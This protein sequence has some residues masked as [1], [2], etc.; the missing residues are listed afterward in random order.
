MKKILLLLASLICLHSLLLAQSSIYKLQNNLTR[1]GIANLSIKIDVISNTQAALIFSRGGGI[2][3]AQSRD[4]LTNQLGLRQGIDLL[5]DDG[6]INTGSTT[7]QKFHQ[8]YKGVKVEH[9]VINTTGSNGNVAMIQMEFYTINDD[10]KTTPSLSESAALQKAVDFVGAQLYVWNGYTGNDPDYMQPKGELVIVPTYKTPGEVCLAYKFNIYSLQPV[11]RAWVYVNAWDGTIVLNDPI[12]K[13]VSSHTIRDTIK[14]IGSNTN[15]TMAAENTHDVNRTSANVVGTADTRY[16]GLQNIVTDNNS[17]VAGKPY[18][19]RETRNGQNIITLNYQRR[20]GNTNVNND[21]LAVDFLDDDNNWTAAEYNNSNFDNAALDIHFN[22]ELVSDYWLNVHNRHGWNNNNGEVRNYV[23]VTEDQFNSSGYS[24]GTYFMSNAYW[25]GKTMHF[26]DGNGDPTVENVRAGLDVCSHEL[27]HGVTETNNHLIYQWE[28]G[29]LNEGFS[30]IWAA[31]IANYG[32]THYNLP[33]ELTWRYGEKY[34]HQDL[35]DKKGLRDLSDPEIYEHPATYKGKYWQDATLQ[36]CRNFGNTDNCGVHNNSGVLDKWFYLITQ[37]ETSTNSLGTSYSVTGLGFGITQKIAYLTSLNMTPNASYATA[38]TVSINAAITLYGDGSPE[39]QTVKD[40]WVAVGVDSNI[41]NT[42]NTSVFATNNFTAIAVDG[43]G[44]VWAGT[45]GSGLYRYTNNAWEKRAE[46][47]NLRIND[48][49]TDKD[50]NI[51][52]AESGTVAGGTQAIAGG[53]YYLKSPYGASDN[54]LY[55]I[56]AQANIP[57]RNARCIFIDTTRKTDGT[58]PAV[59]AATQSYITSGNSASGMLSQGLYNNTPYFQRVSGG[60]NIASNT[61]GI[62]TVGGNASEVWGFAQANNGTNQLLTYNAGTN[63]F[64][65]AYDN[66]TTPVIPANFIARSIYGDSKNR[67]WIALANNGLLVFDENRKW[68]YVNI[69]DAFPAGTQAYFNAI[70]GNKKGDVYI[71]TNNGIVFFERG[72]GLPANIDNPNNYKLFTKANGLPSN[73]VTALAYDTSRFK[74]MVATDNGVVFFEPLCLGLYCK[75]YKAQ[76]DITSASAKS[77]NWSDP[78]VWSN[79]KVPDS[80]TAVTITHNIAV[81]INAQC[82]ELTVLPGGSVT[83]NTGMNLKLF[84]EKQPVQTTTE[85][86]NGT[87]KKNE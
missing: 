74:L 83:L 35:G 28:S 14:N 67:M 62:A 68:H 50:G 15:A 64:I 44:D 81:D 72:D 27:G 2:P 75:Q 73:Q 9:G 61:A 87:L 11:S 13:H 37:G 54:Y 53:I 48:I 60:L 66:S 70:C 58:N 82:K 7:V 80:L 8:Y 32:K 3:E 52:I 84:P 18:R 10:F 86:V 45:G 71:G 26:G 17:G 38:K 24:V 20:T 12:I 55:T 76:E 41:Y 19:L 39:V 23:H 63:A 56:G 30:D 29:A 16:I 79:N 46:L 78:T 5:T 33:G 6:L 25:N 59:W 69:A 47:P 40:A 57:S 51:W 34:A 65:T 42:T 22:M 49:K 43:H 1:G 36:T 77:G 85:Q 4:W 31:C 21:G